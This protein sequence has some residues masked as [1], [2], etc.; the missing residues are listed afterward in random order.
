MSGGQEL[1]VLELLL[2]LQRDLVFF[3]P[4]LWPGTLFTKVCLLVEVRMVLCS[5]GTLGNDAEARLV[6]C[7]PLLVPV[8]TLVLFRVEK[9][10]GGM[11]MAHEG[12]IW[13]LA[14]HPLGHILCSGSNDHTRLDT[15]WFLL[16]TLFLLVVQ[17]LNTPV[18]ICSSL[19]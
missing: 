15:R 7:A 19:S 8:F 2:V 4:Q 5:S 17:L 10:V 18:S 13:S 1:P 3:C 6:L 11:E 9:E 12:M 16:R 14:W